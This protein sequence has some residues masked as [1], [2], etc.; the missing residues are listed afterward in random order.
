MNKIQLKAIKSPIRDQETLQKEWA[1]PRIFACQNKKK[2]WLVNLFV[3]EKPTRKDP[4]VPEYEW[5]AIIR[6]YNR[7]SK[8]QKSV[9]TWLPGEYDTACRMLVAELDHV[10]RLISSN[11]EDGAHFIRMT[12]TLTEDEH[13]IFEHPELLGN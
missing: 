9:A 8:L 4:D 5:T 10:G 13:E 11:V 2:V 3:A 7:R 6:L 12:R 1:N